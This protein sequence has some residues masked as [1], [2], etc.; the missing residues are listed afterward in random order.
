[1]DDMDFTKPQVEKP[2]ASAP[3]K[4]AQSRFYDSAAAAKVFREAGREERFAA[5]QVIFEEDEKAKGGLFSKSSSRMYF[6]AEG[7]VA[8]SIRGK[9]LDIVKA[10]EVFGEMAVISGQPRILHH[11]HDVTALMVRIDAVSTLM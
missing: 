1:M 8:L 3:F 5:G 11:P 2:A 7:E 9:P 4:A 6:L 10:G